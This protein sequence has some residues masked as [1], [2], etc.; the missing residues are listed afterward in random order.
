MICC[1][2]NLMSNIKSKNK[3][4][5]ADDVKPPPQMFPSAVR[6]MKKLCNLLPKIIFNAI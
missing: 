1:S 3:H 2:R 5:S 4:C 6:A